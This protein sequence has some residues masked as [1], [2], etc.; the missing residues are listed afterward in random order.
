MGLHAQL[1]LATEG[2]TYIVCGVRLE[3]LVFIVELSQGQFYS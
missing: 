2:R 3:F 1:I